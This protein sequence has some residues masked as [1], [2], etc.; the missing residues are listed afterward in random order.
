MNG[1]LPAA[2]LVTVC[3]VLGACGPKANPTPRAD[4]NVAQ[5]TYKPGMGDLM[6]SLQLRHA[7]L[8]Y[9]GHAH[10]WPLAKFELHEMD[11]T[12]ERI[13]RWHP[14]EDDIPLAPMLEAHMKGALAAL[15]ES[16]AQED[17]AAFEAAFDRFTSGCNACHQSMNHGFIVIQRPSSPPVSNQ[18]WEAMSD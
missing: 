18:R 14:E 4:H 9:A 1:S 3:L 13:L 16:T 12:F 15:D 7:K 17:S 6:S 2:L 10:N 5:E 11:E 8:W